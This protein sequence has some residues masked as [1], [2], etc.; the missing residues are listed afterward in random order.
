[1]RVLTRYLVQEFL[2]K[3]FFC[4][5]IFIFL[6]LFIDFTQKVDNFLEANASKG[7]M[8]LYFLYETPF[9][10]A[11]LMPSA[12]LIALLIT[13]VLMR[14]NNEIIAMKSCG[15]SIFSIFRP[16][17]ATCFILGIF[18]FLVSETI[19]PYTSSKSGKI[20]KMEAEQWDAAHLN[21][22]FDIWYRSPNAIYRINIFDHKKRTMENA[23]FF[24]FD[25]RFRLI[26]RID[27]RRGVW[28]NGRWRLEDGVV[29]VIGDG[30]NYDVKR[31]HHLLLRIPEPP[32]TFVKEEKR[33]EQMSYWQLQRYAERIGQEGYDN[34]KY[35]VDLYVKTAF[36]WAVLILA[37]MGIPISL[38]GFCDRVP[39]A[40]AAGIGICF[41]YMLVFGI[42]R[43]LGLSG[44][45]P[46]FLSAWFA[47]LIFF[48]IGFYGMIHAER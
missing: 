31:F 47:N 21:R 23:S 7:A 41:V 18:A 34:T 11:Q 12:G 30:G 39:L 29:Q 27:C 1:M 5:V 8:L 28:E 48:F 6:Y 13:I 36:P 20:W 44:I 9:I 45:L 2:A 16:I 24:F 40:L 3:F 43:S 46:P 38:A 15:M 42:S 17:M 26:K 35:L 33:P 19:V 37:I 22:S 4:E 10:S 32:E 14:R 25:D